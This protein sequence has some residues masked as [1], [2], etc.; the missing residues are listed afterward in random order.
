MVSQ[1]VSLL[2]SHKGCGPESLL[3]KLHSRSLKR[4]PGNTVSGKLHRRSAKHSPGN[5]VCAMRPRGT[6]TGL[7]SVYADAVKKTMA[8]RQPAARA[9]CP[10]KK[11]IACAQPAARA[12]CPAKK[13][14][15]CA[16]PAAR[17]RSAVNEARRKRRRATLVT[18]G[19][20][21]AE[22]ASLM[23]LV[24]RAGETDVQHLERHPAAEPR[25]AKT[26][27]RCAYLANRKRWSRFARL[28]RRPQRTGRDDEDDTFLAPRPAHLGGY[29]GLGC[30]LC[31]AAADDEPCRKKRAR[32]LNQPSDHGP[33]NG[34]S[35]SRCHTV[36][37]RFALR[38]A[39]LHKVMSSA[40]INH[41]TSLQH[42][43]AMDV[44]MSTQTDVASA[45]VQ[46]AAEGPSECRQP[47]TYG[48][49]ESTKAVMK[50][51]EV[52]KAFSGRVP[53]VRDWVNAWAETSS[54]VS[55]NKQEGM[56]SKKQETCRRRQR[57]KQLSIM[58]EVC[59]VRQ[60]KRAREATSMT[61]S[62]DAW[63]TRKVMRFRADTPS[64]PYFHDGVMGVIHL[65]YNSGAASTANGGAS[66]ACGVQ[67]HIEEDHAELATRSLESMLTRFCT[68]REKGASGRRRKHV[69]RFD[70]ALYDH[71]RRV[72][73]VL[74]ADGGSG[75][76]R[77][78][79]MACQRFFTNVCMLIRD[80]AHA[81]RISIQTPIKIEEMYGAV[82]KELIGQRHALIPDI[83]NSGKWRCQLKAIQK[84][85]LRIP[86]LTREGALKVVLHHFSM[87]KQRF[88]SCADPLA[89][90]CLLLMPICMLLSFKSCDER[91]GRSERDLAQGLLR[92]FTPKF[93]LAAGVAADWGLLTMEFLRLF[94]R[95][96]HDIA[97][98]ANE[99]RMFT[100]KIR[101]CFVQGAVFK[102]Q[103]NNAVATA[104]GSSSSQPAAASSSG[105]PAA[106]S[107]VAHAQRPENTPQFITER[108]RLQMQTR[109]VFQCGNSQQVVWGACSQEDV[110]DLSARI[111]T[112]AKAML[113]RIHAEF[114][115]PREAFSCM[116]MVEVHKAFVL[117]DATWKAKLKAHLGAIA[118]AFQ[119]DPAIAQL[120]YIDA[121]PELVKIW[122]SIPH[123][124]E[125][126]FHNRE[127]WV[128][129]LSKT[130]LD[131]HFRWRSAP[132]RV[133]PQLVRLYISVLDGEVQVERDLAAL[134]RFLE[135]HS[136][137]LDPSTIEDLLLLALS[138]PSAPREIAV[139]A[140]GGGLEATD[141]TFEC[142]LLWLIVYGR[143]FGFK[144]QM[145]TRKPAARQRTL[146]TWKQA[147]SMALE[148]A[149]ISTAAPIPT[150]APHS[151]Q[152][153][154]WN[155]KFGKFAK[156]TRTKRARNLLAQKGKEG[157][158][159]PGV[160][161]AMPRSFR[162]FPD[163]PRVA[164]LP[165][166]PGEFV[167][168]VRVERGAHACKSALAVVMDCWDRLH[169]PVADA[170]WV[171]HLI[172]IVGLGLPVT[173]RQSW[174][175]KQGRVDRQD[176]QK[177]FVPHIPLAKK[178]KVEFSMDLRLGL[179][180]EDVKAAL[181]HCCRGIGS[182]WKFSKRL[183][184]S[185][186][187]GLQQLHVTDLAQLWS[188]LQ[189]QR[190][191]VNLRGGGR[192]FFSP[193][194]LMVCAL[195]LRR[196]SIS[197]C[198]AIDSPGSVI[199]SGP[200]P[201]EHCGRG[202]IGHDG[203]C[204][205]TV[206]CWT[207]LCDRGWGSRGPHRAPCAEKKSEN[208]I[209]PGIQEFRK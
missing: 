35:L 125:K 91:A 95:L 61:L 198:G 52:E 171:L 85:C 30:T 126:R 190:R 51:C 207:V 168:K 53:Q 31:A 96:H 192:V 63:N 13:T 26:C 86:S 154:G 60:Q 199:A 163:M 65:E 88:E 24:G 149:R 108:V 101:A 204:S 11:T 186:G 188:W 110:A 191:V 25:W 17:A 106:A 132:F 193:K 100:A 16:P 144:K 104:A 173:T 56:A 157:I 34:R 21:C 80:P 75:E 28:P 39:T 142:A 122:R 55:F 143:R 81:V 5:S 182:T 54:C 102:A 165:D 97:M 94:D 172:Y 161:A 92:K 139:P 120:E 76:R 177:I 107:S 176:V 59:R 128:H 156:L 145:S 189:A 105:Q 116:N 78:L 178:V 129:M 69:R 135:A 79:Y 183:S 44:L 197:Q 109:A 147:R 185:P 6:S 73:R 64:A 93:L 48:P 209:S 23:A 38:R 19:G 118:E 148:A 2:A 175:L 58:A 146:N 138:G 117:G 83:Q 46:P 41:T 181:Q 82:Y 1:L 127:V 68:R 151:Q 123:R 208:S 140:C 66:T 196:V 159:K 40:I 71:I 203:L 3:W 166:S 90:F 99:L 130:F 37:S 8:R 158:P 67:E 4:S 32:L 18:T 167:A 152:N 205:V 155:A 27:P 15:A 194:K 57:R 195:S 202:A 72:T 119:W 153:I 10:A 49:A 136:G 200:P 115:G 150:P 121:A 162:T 45:R 179:E 164:F 160:R 87:A 111:S 174:K 43:L 113:A 131:A 133:I 134:R 124:G 180:H 74:A 169:E 137:N 201:K 22:Q 84:E 29:W 62:V 114:A 170:K 112:A 33:N 42:R 47:A 70:Q 89:K 50:A 187:K 9:R 77:F 20:V 98:S 184:R 141:F 12:R 14:M 103:R 206:A 36:W 7:T